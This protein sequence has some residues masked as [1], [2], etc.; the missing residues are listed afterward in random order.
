MGEGKI[1]PPLRPL[2]I[3]SALPRRSIAALIFR[4]GV[5]PS[6]VR[7]AFCVRAS[8]VLALGLKFPLSNPLVGRHERPSPRKR[9]YASARRGRLQSWNQNSGSHETDLDSAG[10]PPE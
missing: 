3:A 1:R 2:A 8:I 6:K 10:A 4:S 7:P 9:P 5:P